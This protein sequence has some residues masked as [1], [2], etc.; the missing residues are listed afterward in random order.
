MVGNIMPDWRGIG[1]TIIETPIPIT[2]KEDGR[3]QPASY[4]QGTGGR[5]LVTRCIF[6]GKW[7]QCT[8]GRKSPHDPGCTYFRHDIMCDKLVIGEKEYN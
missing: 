5:D 6:N 4:P 7:E 3:K 2:P 8:F 1:N